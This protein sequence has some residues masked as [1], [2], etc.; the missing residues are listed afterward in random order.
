MMM[1]K[2]RNAFPPFSLPQHFQFTRTPFSSTLSSSPSPS[3]SS[4]CSSSSSSSSSSSVEHFNSP[5]CRRRRRRWISTYFP[6]FEYA[7]PIQLCRTGNRTEPE[8]RSVPCFN[9]GSQRLIHTSTVRL[10]W[11]NI[12][13]IPSSY[14]YRNR[15]TF[16]NNHSN[17]P[18]DEN[19]LN[20]NRRSDSFSPSSSTSIPDYNRFNRKD[21]N[22][23]HFDDPN[24]EIMQVRICI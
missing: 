2:T 11:S 4:S 17:P 10:G 18:N 6:F 23:G 13:S 3:S 21:D 9:F 19:L 12:S 5:L 14:I 1:I 24:L 15:N 16:T 22:Y 20:K 7:R 8:N